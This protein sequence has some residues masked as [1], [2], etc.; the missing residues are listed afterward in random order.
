MMN[1]NY[2]RCICSFVNLQGIFTMI[3]VNSKMPSMTR[4]ILCHPWQQKNDQ[5]RIYASAHKKSPKNTWQRDTTL[6]AWRRSPRYGTNNGGKGPSSVR[7]TALGFCPH[8]KMQGVQISITLQM[9]MTTTQKLSSRFDTSWDWPRLRRKNM[10]T[11]HA[12]SWGHNTTL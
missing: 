4:Q 6:T 9:I 5:K 11:Q 3:W 7:S 2:C 12:E 8:P 1:A 10:A